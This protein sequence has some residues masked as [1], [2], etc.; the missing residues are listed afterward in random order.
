MV[1]DKHPLIPIDKTQLHESIFIFNQIPLGVMI[2]WVNFQKL[3]YGSHLVSKNLQTKT[4]LIKGKI[5]FWASKRPAQWLA[6]GQ[7]DAPN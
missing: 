5:L 6:L 7:L 3:A 4:S 2:N 1:E